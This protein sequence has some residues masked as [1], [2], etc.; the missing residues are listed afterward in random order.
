MARIALVDDDPEHIRRMKDY[1][2]RYE[3]EEGLKFSVE[4]FTNGLNFVEDYDGSFDVIFLDI[5]MPHLD[6]LE[7]AR[8]IRKMD[9]SVGIVFVTNMAQYAIRGYEVDAVDFVVKPVGYFVFTDKLKKALR[10]LQRNRE[11]EVLIQTG[12]TVVKIPVSQILYIEKSKNYLE[13]HTRD[14]VYRIRGTIADVE[15][16]FRKEGFSKCISGCLVN[17]KYVTKAS[18]DTVWLSDITLPISRQRRN[19]FKEDLMRYMGG[20]Y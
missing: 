10:V 8:R 15:D 13:Y 16:A 11:R 4:V 18:K 12:D 6:G 14:Q 7:A 17:L 9:Q 2:K 19:G 20:G 1:L 5:E 3:E